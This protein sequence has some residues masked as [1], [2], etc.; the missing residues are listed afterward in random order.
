MWLDAAT[1]PLG[2]PLTQLVWRVF[3]LA[4]YQEF[5]LQL[6]WVPFVGLVLG[7]LAE[8]SMRQSLIQSS[9]DFMV[10]LERP[11]SGSIM[12]VAIFLIVLPALKV[13]KDAIS[14]RRVSGGE[15]AD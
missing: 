5:P 10:F 15:G 11:I 8:A 14:S 12:A 3:G 9:G 13:L 7:P 2:D 6:G 1:A 4:I